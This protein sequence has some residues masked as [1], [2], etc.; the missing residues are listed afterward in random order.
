MLK[1][2]RLRAIFAVLAA[3]TAS[4]TL[5]GTA[6][7]S[8]R[9]VVIDT[10]DVCDPASFNAAG[11]PCHR[12]DGS[13][14]RATVD[15]LLAS[16]P[17]GGHGAWRFKNDDVEVKAGEPVYV[18]LAR[19]GEFHTFT[20]VAKFGPGCVPPINIPMF[21]KPDL[22][23]ECFPLVDTPDGPVPTPLITD[24]IP[25][26]GSSV[27]VPA[28][29]LTRGTNLFVCMIHPWMKAKVTVQ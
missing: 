10:E 6:G 27:R 4:L 7:A 14:K 22:A 13:G 15:E 12:I 8:S 1:G 19:G 24:G 2:S 17:K 28:A 11:I 16:L 23:P 5:A 20:K 25:V 18:R 21:G 29:K 9:G 26:D 3:L